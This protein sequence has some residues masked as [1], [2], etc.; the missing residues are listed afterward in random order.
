[1]KALHYNIDAEQS[2][3][4][5][6]LLDFGA[7]EA[8]QPLKAEHFADWRHR[9]IYTAISGV[10]ADGKHP[11]P[12]VVSTL[13]GKELEECGG[14][15]YL[16]ALRDSV[17]G[18]RNTDRYA[19]VIR[20]KALERGLLAATEDVKA[21]VA[22]SLPV[23]EKINASTQLFTGLAQGHVRKLPRHIL[24]IAVERSQY[25]DDVHT[26]QVIP[27][28]PT[29]IPMLDGSIGGGLKP[30]MLMILAARP[31]V[32][33]SSLAQ[34]LAMTIAE[35]G[36]VTLFLSLEMPETE[37]ADRAVSHM[38]RINSQALLTGKM[39]ADGWS[40][41]TQAM[42]DMRGHP[43]YVDDQPALTL[44][45]IMTKARAVPNLKF[46]VLDYLQLCQGSGDNRNSQ[47]EE[48]TRGL[49]AL[50]KSLNI[51]V[52]ALSQLNRQVEQ[53]SNKRPNLSDLRDSGAIEQ[54]ADVVMFLWR[55]REF[56][57]GRRLIGLG[58]DKNRQGRTCEFGLDF[59][60]SIQRWGESTE[61]LHYDKPAAPKKG[62]DA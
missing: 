41:A 14:V 31:S 62:F 56:A 38:G 22:Q 45:D 34:Q 18:S 3:L 43:L 28:W 21:I 13:L 20:D 42:E 23:E 61:P 29:R 5:A 33:K 24:E 30:G 19:K 35:Q 55:V 17:P 9:S 15:E 44:T 60:G 54:D 48:I 46:L 11:D 4:G 7:W 16:N 40:H 8:A 26:G 36:L 2:V 58:V 49:K 25:Y 59:D 27:G 6:M 57:D 52:L 51:C 12:V 39:S 1:M 50:A 32:G 37:V 53:R 10:V 47:I